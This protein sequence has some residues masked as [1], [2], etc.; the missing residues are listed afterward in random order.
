MGG[1]TVIV[2]ATLTKRVQRNN[3]DIWSL[4]PGKVHSIR[5]PTVAR[6]I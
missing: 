5:E 2:L 6:V 3:K 1:E 4:K